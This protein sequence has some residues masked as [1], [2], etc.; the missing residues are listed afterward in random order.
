MN[1][2][3]IPIDKEIPVKT[4]TSI[5]V[6]TDNKGIIEYANDYFIEL[7]GYDIGEI[8]G[9]DIS[10]VKH[11]EMPDIIFDHIWERLLKKENAKA[12]LKNITKTGEYFW[13]QAKFDFKVN[14]NTR[15]IENFY[16]Y[17]SPVSKKSILEL[18]KLYKIISKIE[19]HTGIDIAEN[20]FLGHLEGKSQN[21]DDFIEEYYQY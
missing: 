1:S 19:K 9:K 12:I 13:L 14:E 4:N 7:S 10:I 15:E 11:P 3:L 5:M 16:A 6:K 20:Y 8:I 21:Y 17:Y 18:D 2:K